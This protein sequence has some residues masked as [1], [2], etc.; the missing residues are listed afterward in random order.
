MAVFTGICKRI[1]EWRRAMASQR[2]TARFS[3]ISA[4]V[5]GSEGALRN[6]GSHRGLRQRRRRGSAAEIDRAAM[7]P[8][9]RTQLRRMSE[10]NNDAKTSFEKRL[11][12]VICVILI[13]GF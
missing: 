13:D 9:R 7:V 6:G 10:A 1:E 5:M 8:R 11:V 12:F 3:E 2:S 4:S